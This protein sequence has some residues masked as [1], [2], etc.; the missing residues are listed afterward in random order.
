M[1][2]EAPVFGVQEPGRIYAPRPGVYGIALDEA[3]HVLVVDAG[4]RLALPGGGMEP[5]ETA[6]EALRR[7]VAEETGYRIAVG[8]PVGEAVQHV[9]AADYGRHWAK[10]CSYL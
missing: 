4:E 2:E 7:E 9:F 8:E 6:E 10:H 1:T 3:G 5:G